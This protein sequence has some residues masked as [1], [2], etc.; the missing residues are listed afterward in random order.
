MTTQQLSCLCHLNIHSTSY[1]R[2]V[3]LYSKGNYDTLSE[4]I[5][6]HI[7]K[8]G[9]N[10]IFPECWKFSYVIPIPKTGDENDPSNHRP[11][12]LLNPL[13]KVMERII[14][15]HIY[16]YLHSNDLIYRNQSGFLPGHST[17]FQLTDIYHSICNT[18]DNNQFS[19]MVF[20]DISKAFDCVWH[21]GLTFILKQYGISNDLL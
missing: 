11:I 21:K 12:S 18:F 14:F 20:C 4:N 7:I 6:N 8:Y 16:S 2:T 10:G 1:K 15:K 17:I 9:K 19:C 5:T 13:G 3:C